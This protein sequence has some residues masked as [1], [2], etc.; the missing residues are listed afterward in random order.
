ME[1]LPILISLGAAF[2]ISIR[3]LSVSHSDPTTA[4]AIIAEQ[5]YGTVLVSTLLLGL[6]QLPILVI[7]VTSF[8]TAQSGKV[9]RE[10]ILL[11]LVTFVTGFAITPWPLY[12]YAIFV[13]AALTY[14][15]LHEASPPMRRSR[16]FFIIAINVLVFLLVAWSDT[17]WLPREQIDT[18]AGPRF[19]A[20]VLGE[21]DQSLV[22]MEDSTRY[23]GLLPKTSVEHRHY[24]QR[25]SDWGWDALS[26]VTRGK[27]AGESLFGLL[28]RRPSPDY[29]DCVMNGDWRLQLTGR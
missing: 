12:L 16:L 5:G 15:Y 22:V 3:L 28:S 25:A 9:S 11:L 6:P 23:V 18:V 24:C 7:V 4:L 8:F 19:S 14:P 13:T 20:F 21:S 2:F 1:H 27:W 17:M 10:V 26:Q 29:P